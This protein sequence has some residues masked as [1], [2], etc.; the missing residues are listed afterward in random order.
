[1]EIVYFEKKTFEEFAAKIERFI[2][3]ISD[4]PHLKGEKKAGKWLD[5][6]EVC[7]N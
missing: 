2:Q 7:Q 5:Y 4:I 1:M 6:Q 3:K